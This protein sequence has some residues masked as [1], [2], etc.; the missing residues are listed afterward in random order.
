[1]E[2]I[3]STIPLVERVRLVLFIEQQ[4]LHPKQENVS[5]LPTPVAS[6]GK[7]KLTCG[8]TGA[9]Q[10]GQVGAF[11][12]C[13]LGDVGSPLQHPARSTSSAVSVVAALVH[14]FFTHL[15]KPM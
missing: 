8:R 15:N 13:R 7:A 11:L 2:P 14:P 6:L 4:C 1:M 3:H 9:W 5:L 12:S 10:S